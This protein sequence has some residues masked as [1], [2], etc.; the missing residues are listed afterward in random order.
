MK[1]GTSKINNTEWG[2]FIGFLILVDIIQVV[3]EWVTLALSSVFVNPYIDIFLTMSIP[4]YMYLRGEN[5]AD[6]KRLLGLLGGLL[7]EL[8][9]GVD[10]F[11]LWSL[12]GLY[13]FSLSKSNRILKQIP[14]ADNAG[15]ITGEKK[16]GEEENDT[17]KAA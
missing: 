10:E 4:F 2:L 17:E 16:D 13:L 1:E 8:T 6:P 15:Q 9:P 5:M 14:G 11:P 12:Y 7:G 3:L